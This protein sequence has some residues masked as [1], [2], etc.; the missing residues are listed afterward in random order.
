MV[1]GFRAAMLIGILSTT[2]IGVILGVTEL[3]KGAWVSFSLPDTSAVFM[4]MD[5]KGALSHG[6]LSI[7]FTLTMVDLFD[8]MGVL[9]GLARK[10]GF[11]RP[12]G[13]I[14][15]LDRAFVTDSIGTMFSACM[16]TT[17]AT[18]YLESASALPRAA[19]RPDSRHDGGLL[20]ARAFL[21]SARRH[22]ACVCNRT[23]SHHR[24]GA[25]D[26]GGRAHPF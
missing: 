26:A 10:C 18:S 1:K 11:M 5:L 22:G 4:Q 16:G 24:G 6:L 25:H 12:D 15:N 19:A 13:E 23:D 8:N 7:I 21:H 3:P 20:R 14:R 9:I 2:A 17:T